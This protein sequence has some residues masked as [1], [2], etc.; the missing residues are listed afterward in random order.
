MTDITRYAAYLVPEGALGHFG[1][2]WL[3]WDLR[4]GHAVPQLDVTGLPRSITVL[5]AQARKYGFHATIKPPFRLAHGQSEVGLEQAMAALCADSAP[6]TC[7]RLALTDLHGFL[8]LTPQGDTTALD[9]FAARTVAALDPFRAAA[10]SEETASRRAAGLTPAQEANL[11]RWGYPYVMD[12]FRCH[13]T[14]TGRLSPA[15]STVVGAALGPHLIRL[16][17]G[18]FRVDSLCLV[19]EQAG[20]GFRL[21]HRYALS[22]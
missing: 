8:A 5:T 16:L 10:R 14:L 22:G 3:G 4:T 1:A 2:D 15:D 11:L 13:F 18:P 17:A 21:L 9:A 20:G 19:G 7:D 12:E 6:V